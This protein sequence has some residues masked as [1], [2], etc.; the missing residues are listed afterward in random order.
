[1]ADAPYQPRDAASTAMDPTA[2]IMYLIAGT[3]NGGH[4]LST[5]W[6][7]TLTSPYDGILIFLCSRI[8]DHIIIR[9]LL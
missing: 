5:V 8:L 1:M 6:A 9:F 3:D 7:L 4:T 2:G